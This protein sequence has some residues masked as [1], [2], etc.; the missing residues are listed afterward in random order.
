MTTEELVDRVRIRR[1][2]Y[3]DYRVTI[4]YR[5]NEYCCRSTDSLAYDTITSYLC[6]NNNCYYYKSPN[7]AYMSL[8]CVCKR[9][10]GLK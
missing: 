10:N 3:G 1:I 6:G 4:R 9:V 8:Y 7:Q 2:G 5:G